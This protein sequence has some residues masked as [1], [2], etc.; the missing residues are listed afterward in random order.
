MWVELQEG[1][2]RKPWDISNF[3]GQEVE[4]RGKFGKGGETVLRKRTALWR[5][6]ESKPG[7]FANMKLMDDLYR[8]RFN[9]SEGRSQDTRVKK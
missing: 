5:V 2:K 6:Q 7:Q 1:E 3:L 9:S 8:S 4:K